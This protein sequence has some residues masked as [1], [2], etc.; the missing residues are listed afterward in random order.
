MQ[1]M[2]VCSAQKGRDE[3]LQAVCDIICDARDPAQLTA[4]KNGIDRGSDKFDLFHLV[5]RTLDERKRKLVLD[6][7]ERVNRPAAAAD[8]LQRPV[9]LLSDVD[10]TLFQGWKDAGF[11]SKSVYPGVLA[12]HA[13]ILGTGTAATERQWGDEEEDAPQPAASNAVE[14]VASAA[15]ARAKPAVSQVVFI[16]ARPSMMKESSHHAVRSVGVR[17]CVVLTGKLRSLVTHAAMAARKVENFRRFVALY[18]EYRYVWLGDSGQ[19]DI[20]AAR[21]FL[22]LARTELRVPLSAFIHDITS[23]DTVTPTLDV[24]ARVALAREGIAVFDTYVDAAFI[25]LKVRRAPAH[26]R[27]AR[28]AHA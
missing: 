18:P 19:G 6:H 20:E 25:A 13:A 3:P 9:K 26:T 28:A 1:E 12:F 16:S 24:D 21:Q 27:H 5:Y 11:P 4:L 22:H 23:S 10:D 7:I 15:M 14:A 2:L 17:G 8:P